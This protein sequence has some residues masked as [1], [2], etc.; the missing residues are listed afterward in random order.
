MKVE[1]FIRL[2]RCQFDYIS[3]LLISI[4]AVS[5]FHEIVSIF[6][7]TKSIKHMK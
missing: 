7:E 1:Y 2:Q 6:V 4:N 3:F 5:I